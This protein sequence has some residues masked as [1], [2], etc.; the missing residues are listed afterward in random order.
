[1][2]QFDDW[3]GGV[4]VPA[5]TPTIKSVRYL[6][7]GFREKIDSTMGIAKS[8][9]YIEVDVCRAVARHTCARRLRIRKKSNR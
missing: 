3:N 1:M 2:R 5:D 4:C 6:N 8:P 7:G 9:L